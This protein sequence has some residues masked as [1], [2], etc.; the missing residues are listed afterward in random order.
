MH[1]SAPVLIPRLSTQ[2]ERLRGRLLSAKDC[3]AY[4]QIHLTPRLRRFPGVARMKKS[5]GEMRKKIR[6]II[7][8]GILFDASL[9]AVDDLLLQENIPLD[10]LSLRDHRHPLLLVL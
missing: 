10:A 5:T 1:Y 4:V 8:R 7:F 3:S 6:I 9:D 2:W